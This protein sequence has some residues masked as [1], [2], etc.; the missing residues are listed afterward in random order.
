MVELRVLG[1]V[2]LADGDG[3]IA[4]PAPKH[5]RL[6]LALTIAGG[7]ACS[8]DELVDAVWGES[9]PASARK[10][11]Q[12]YV[13]AL[14]KVLPEEVALVTEGPGYALRLPAES[15]DA[16]RFET[17]VA[18][19]A[20]ALATGNPALASSLADRALALWRGP[21]LADVAYD[22]FARGEAERLEELR[23][24]ALE[25]RLEA[26]LR[27]GRDVLAE[28]LALAREHPQR[29]RMQA[30]AM[31]ALYGSGRQTE[32]LDLYA[33]LR[34][35]LQ[36][37][38]GLE[39]GPELR[40]LQRRILQQ[41][42]E[43]ELTSATETAHTLP[44]PPNPLVGRERELEA[45]RSLLARR[46]VRL[47]VLTGAGGS[48]KTRLALEA[49]REAA[50]SFANGATL[51]ELASVRDPELV[52]PTI[53]RTL[54]I[55]DVAGQGPLESIGSALR[56]RELLLVLDNAEHVRAATPALVDLLARAPRLLLLVTSRAVLHVSGE[57]VF[58]V[59][60][61][62]EAAA[63]EL[64][65]QRARSLQ[66]AFRL[67]A[68]DR[69]DVRDICDRVDRL[70]LA[71]EL[72]AARIRILTPAALLER[73]E[74]RLS[75]LTGGPHDLP[76]RQQTLRET[77]DWS[78]GL[79]ARDERAFLARLSIFVGGFT[80]DAAA[81]VCLEG[82]EHRSLDLV[83]AL[84]DASLV[85]AEEHGGRMRF[86]LLETVREYAADR[87]RE[88]EPDE[89]AR[90]HAQWCLALVEAAEPELS[91]DQQ[92]SWFAKLEAEH[93]NLR[94]A[95]SFLTRTDDRG[96]RLRLTVA[97]SRFW[98]VRGYLAEGRRRLEEAL[99]E[100]GGE[101]PLLLRRALTAAAALALL[102][103]DYEAATSFSE[104]ALV[105]A[106]RGGEPRFVAN[107]LSNLG[108]IV[109]A[110]GEYE[111]AA[112]VLEEAVTLARA[113]GDERIAALAIN[114]LGDLALTTGDYE[115][116]SPL[117][118]ESHALLHARGDTANI[119]RSLFNI[120]AVELM[121][122]RRETARSRFRESLALAQAM[123][124][125]EDIAWCLEGLASLAAAEE[126]G[127]RASILLGAAG[128]LL[129]QMGADFKP[130]ERKLHEATEARARAL[131]GDAGHAAALGRGAAMPL[132]D[133]LELALEGSAVAVP[134]VPERRV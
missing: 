98:Y 81:A 30:L 51:V 43:L 133:A 14:R 85:A 107:A 97:L 132:T 121:L 69:A 104:E 18:D 45:L 134:R 61:L 37:E 93:D 75:F 33:A 66:P 1:P 67:S 58:P 73:L 11:L 34:A 31:H 29:E 80:I 17:H 15:L 130:F 128:G 118:E 39:P 108:A 50:A 48:G 23:L 25:Q 120:G 92:S 117:F 90:R 70:P 22:D 125:K 42:P 91:G 40:E 72:A 123:D 4:L 10:L 7:R 116:A 24:V 3:A 5:R 115:R 71:I 126:A 12:V 8:I 127:E 16:D 102:Q 111:R 86:R 96:L 28:A 32:A 95:L 89:T 76:A 54:E 57:H 122:D 82:D 62:E 65:E 79:L 100:A 35:R 77:L 109:L 2:E 74:Q 20:A 9:P 110:A 113:V 46:E 53:A 83:A 131:C 94:A 13:S 114:N 105:A 101:P 19:A 103:G 124:D 52:L 49:A 78:Y 36:D 6:L 129:E 55:P 56:D 21:A 84:A 112:V 59:A 99:S 63:L 64:F 87:L 68:S 88:L 106:R 27:L 38:L 41:D 26:Q 60:P 119:A 47:L 44:V